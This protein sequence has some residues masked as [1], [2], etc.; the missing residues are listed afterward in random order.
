M[1][2]PSLGNVLWST[3]AVDLPYLGWLCYMK[4]ERKWLQTMT[5]MLNIDCS[6]ISGTDFCPPG[7]LLKGHEK[8][9]AFKRFM[10]HEGGGPLNSVAFP[11]PLTSSELFKN[12]S[13]KKYF[14]SALSSLWIHA[15]PIRCCL[16][17]KEMKD[18][19]VFVSAALFQNGK[20]QLV[21]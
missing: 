3:L 20:L 13:R 19:G 9:V 7:N 14:W 1:F 21:Q 11:N 8:F 17:Y 16:I 18:T 6:N 15:P 5:F 4:N 2:T 12:C 10:A